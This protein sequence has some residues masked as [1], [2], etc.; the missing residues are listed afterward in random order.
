MID[1]Q[2]PG[3]DYSGAGPVEYRPAEAAPLGALEQ[4]RS[5][6]EA[7]LLAIPGVT[8]VG[9]GLGAAG[10]EALVVGVVD[11][12]VAARL[13]REIAGV[14]VVVTVTGPVDAQQRR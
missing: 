4:L 3:P 2:N 12:G 8:S 14:A 1:M 5:R 7:R 11:A 10:G 13:P 6:E 9:I